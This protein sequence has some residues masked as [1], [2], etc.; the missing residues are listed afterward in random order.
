MQVGTSSPLPE[1]PSLSGTLGG[2]FGASL[3]VWLRGLAISGI[4]H[5]HTRA[6]PLLAATSGFF[7]MRPPL[8]RGCGFR[9][10]GPEP[11][12]FSGR[13][14]RLRRIASRLRATS[15]GPETDSHARAEPLL[16]AP[17]SVL[18]GRVAD[19]VEQAQVR[20][21][22][23]ERQRRGAAGAERLGERLHHQLVR[24]VGVPPAREGLVEA[25]DPVGADHEQLLLLRAL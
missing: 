5:S 4:G 9:G 1:P 18:V 2:A 21:R 24:V 16:G 23:L 7:E 14:E 12:S 11:P 17:P 25:L 22:A 15:G 20:D 3:R 6:K 19:A 10:V 8:A 13:P